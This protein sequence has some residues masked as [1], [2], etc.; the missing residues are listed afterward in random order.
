[1]VKRLNNKNHP[2]IK[3]PF[4]ETKNNLKTFLIFL[5][6]IVKAITKPVKITQKALKK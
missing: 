4:D 6:F 2:N 3:L 1:M 5:I